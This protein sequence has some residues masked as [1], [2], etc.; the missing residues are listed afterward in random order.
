MQSCRS[1]C[2]ARETSFILFPAIT[3]MSPVLPVLV[4]VTILFEVV[5]LHMKSQIVLLLILVFLLFLPSA[6]L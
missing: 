4:E 5:F 3:K 2:V 1:L 6:T